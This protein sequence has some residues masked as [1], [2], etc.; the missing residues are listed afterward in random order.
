MYLEGFFILV[1]SSAPQFEDLFMFQAGI[2]PQLE[3][4]SWSPLH[5]QLEVLSLSSILSQGSHPQLRSTLRAQLW[6]LS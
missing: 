5:P 3:V 2:H 6:V 1:L 4:L